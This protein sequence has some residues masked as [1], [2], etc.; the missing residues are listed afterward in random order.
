MR[1]LTLQASPFLNLPI[2][3]NLTMFP[4]ILGLCII[5]V[6]DWKNAFVRLS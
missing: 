2:A 4:G 6:F 1:S 5:Y 3:Q